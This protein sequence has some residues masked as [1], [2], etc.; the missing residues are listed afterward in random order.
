MEKYEKARVKL[1]NIKLKKLKSAAKNKAGTTLRIT[2]KYFQDEELPHELHCVKSVSIR[3]F[4]GPYFPA[5]GLNIERHS[6]SLHI[7]SR[8]GKIRTRKTPNTDTFHTVLFLTVRKKTKI[9]NVLANNMSMDIN[10]SKAQWSKLIQSDGFLGKTLGNLGKKDF[11]VPLIKDVLLKL[12]TKAT[13]SVLDK[14]ERKICV[15]GAARAGKRFTLFIITEDMEDIIKI[16]ESLEKSGLLIDGTTEKV[17]H[18]IKKTR[19]CIS[20]CYDDTYDFFIDA[21]CGFF[22]DKS[23][24]W[25]RTR[26]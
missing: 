11:A 3:S 21:T 17:K 23:Y 14:F 19:M 13:S 9:R 2:K 10:L 12:A 22:I 25:E 24:N 6:V 8:Y 1:T 15:L 20:L 16:A 18:E 7:Q 5:F 26:R 4:S